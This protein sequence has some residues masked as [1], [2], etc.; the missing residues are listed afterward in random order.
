MANHV[1]LKERNVRPSSAGEAGIV[2]SYRSS[3]L[4][5]AAKQNRFSP[6]KGTMEGYKKMSSIERSIEKNETARRKEVRSHVIV[7][8]SL[9]PHFILTRRFPSPTRRR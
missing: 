4:K 2:D 5:Y 7:V 3:P 1:N 8:A 9:S 6:L